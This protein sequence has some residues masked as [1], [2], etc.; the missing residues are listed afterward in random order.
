MSDPSE[1]YEAGDAEAR[2]VREQKSLIAALEEGGHHLSFA[3][4]WLKSEGGGGWATNMY[5]VQC[6]AEY[7]GVLLKRWW[8]L[9]PRRPCPLREEG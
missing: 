1:G 9:S 5:C 6:G 2:W 7:K 8:G 3:T 4:T